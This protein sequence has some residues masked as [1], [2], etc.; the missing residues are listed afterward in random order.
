MASTTNPLAVMNG[1][2]VY[3][4]RAKIINVQMNDI[5]TYRVGGN[6][7][8]SVV[9]GTTS[10]MIKVIDLNY[11]ITNQGIYLRLNPEQNSTTKCLLNESRRIFKVRNI[12]YL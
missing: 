6:W 4:E 2:P 11:E 1:S 5:I 12:L 3:G 8:F 10:T 9:T 7:I